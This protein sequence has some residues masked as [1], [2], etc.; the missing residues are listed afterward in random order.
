MLS[1][2]WMLEVARLISSNRKPCT[3]ANCQDCDDC[4]AVKI[5]NDIRKTY[6][7]ENSTA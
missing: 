5:A 1:R 4:R 3:R 6:Q 7:Q 2:E